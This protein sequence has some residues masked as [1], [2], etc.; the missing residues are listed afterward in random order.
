MRK[1]RILRFWKEVQL[2]VAENPVEVLMALVFFLLGI[3]SEWVAKAHEEL[4]N[5]LRYGP[6]LFLLARLFHRQDGRKI[7]K[8]LYYAS[9]LLLAGVCFLHDECSERYL[10]SLLLIQLLYFHATG[11]KYNSTFIQSAL[12][13]VGA[14]LL[15][16]VLGTTV[17]VA[18]MLI[19]SSAIYIF[20]LSGYAY[21]HYL[22]WAIATGFGLALPLFFLVFDRQPRTLDIEGR[23]FHF[24]LNYILS[25]ALVAYAII[26]YIYMVKILVTFTLPKGGVAAMV[27]VFVACLFVLKGCQPFLLRSYF[28]KFYRY[29]SWIALPALLLAWIGTVYRIQEYGWTVARI[30]LVASLLTLS[31]LALLF[32]WRHRDG[33]Y[34]HTA[35]FALIVFSAVS[36]VPGFNV[37]QLEAWSQSARGD[38]PKK[39]EPE[40]LSVHPTTDAIP[41]GPYQQMTVIEKFEVAADSLRI[42]RGDS[43]LYAARLN[44]LLAGQLR[45]AGLAPTDS[46]R[47]ADH[48]RL[49]LIETDSAAIWLEYLNLKRIGG[50]YAVT[51]A[52]PKLYFER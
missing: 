24:L 32:F 27:M 22:P 8:L 25:P 12:H 38:E 46:I 30:Y 17:F 20:E 16:L 43:L 4:F 11:G 49:L 23:P 3:A 41:L 26:L 47:E 35:L 36:Y 42:Y 50:R 6:I 10:V 2:S 13:Y 52:L 28:E 37:T 39:P 14:L 33:Q 5:I 15:G 34:R 40:Y 9:P 44:E 18:L 7:F 45:A 48:N 19:F 21:T 31:L 1:V 51:Y 29:A